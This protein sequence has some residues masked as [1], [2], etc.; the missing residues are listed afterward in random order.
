MNVPRRRL[1]P[2]V[3]PALFLEEIGLREHQELRRRQMKAA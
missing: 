2:F 3:N 1:A